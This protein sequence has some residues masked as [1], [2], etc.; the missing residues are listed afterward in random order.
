MGK[1]K[2]RENKPGKVFRLNALGEER[3]N[4]PWS[5]WGNH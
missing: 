2:R 1:K 3:V 4:F 5:P